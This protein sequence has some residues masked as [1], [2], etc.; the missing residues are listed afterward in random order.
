MKSGR[1]PQTT[2]Y[3]F[4]ASTSH[5]FKRSNPMPLLIRIVCML[6][7]TACI[8][9]STRAAEI[10]EEKS[11]AWSPHR[12]AAPK[13]SRQADGTVTIEGNGTGTCA[14][15]WQ[16]LYSGVTGG[17]TYHLSVHAKHHGLTNARDSI[18][19][20]ALW[21]RWDP[22]S[23]RTQSIPYNYLL[24]NA[25]SPT[26]VE[27]ENVVTAPEGATELTIRYIFRWSAEGSS[28]WSVPHIQK[29]AAAER[30]SV[31]VCVVS[32]AEKSGH[33]TKHPM[34][35]NG[36]GLPSDVE[37]SVN[38]W[39]SLILDACDRKPQLILTPEAIIGGPNP[40][41]N[42]ITLPGP[43]T[44]PFEKIAREHQVYLML[45]VYE[46]S[47][48]ARHNSTVLISPEG[49]VAGVYRKVH[50]ATGEGWSGLT[51]GYSFP[52]FSTAIGRI[53]S[54]ICMDTMLPES[55][56]MLALNGADMICLPI[57]GDLRADRLTPG[58]PMFNEDRWK[59][60]MRTR[61]LDN[62]VNFIIARNEGHG[63][64]I[65]DR[66]GDILAW[67]EGDTNIIEATL[68]TD[69]VRYWD[70]GDVGETTYLLRRPSLYDAFAHD[71]VLGPL[72][73]KP[74]SAQSKTTTHVP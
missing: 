66:R 55:S 35:I 56:R 25:A 7:L 63:S 32:D 4:V 2:D 20:I 54:I 67:N 61:A 51:P 57:M 10:H 71:D 14:G 17:Q 50:L 28:S 68:P 60:V 37:K 41:E 65:I 62:Q 9:S 36:L 40:L 6:V 53:G 11:E 12:I 3:D 22:T 16:F 23:R 8:S 27:F 18:Q 69:T 21:G 26:E 72:T 43:A 58:T 47:G 70:G 1:T 34:S 15:G 5:I 24:P 49:K 44:G 48:D 31:K 13:A 45:G 46:R 59:A 52:V 38:R 74:E 29:A 19:A 42:A 64:C 30:K 33:V 73:S 39:A